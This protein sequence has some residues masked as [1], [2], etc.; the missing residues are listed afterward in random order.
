ML[1]LVLNLERKFLKE[2]QAQ[3]HLARNFQAHMKCLKCQGAR[4]VTIL[5]VI[6]YQPW[7]GKIK[8]IWPV[9]PPVCM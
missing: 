9:S 8:I 4:H 7:V 2:R 6:L 5:V 3:G 1:S